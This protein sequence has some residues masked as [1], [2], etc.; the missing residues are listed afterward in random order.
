MDSG[1]AHALNDLNRFVDQRSGFFEEEAMAVKDHWVAGHGWLEKAQE[2]GPDGRPFVYTQYVDP[3]EM[4]PD[5]FG[6]RRD[7]RDHRYVLRSKWLDLDEA[8]ET[9]PEKEQALLQCIGNSSGYHGIHGMLDPSWEDINEMNYVD[10][11]RKRLRLFEVWYRR[12]A[13]RKA[14]IT[15]DGVVVTI[16]SIGLTNSARAI[17]RAGFE[18]VKTIIDEMWVGIFCGMTLIHH[19]RSPY[20]HGDYP[21]VQYVYSRNKSGMP[22]GWLSEDIMTMQDAHNKRHS[23]A[24]H[25]FNT[26]QAVVTEN[27]VKDMNELAEEMAKPD[28]VIVLEQGRKIDD[29]FQLLSNTEMGQG[30]LAM[31]QHVRQGFD[32]VG[33][34]SQVDQGQAPGDV[35]SDRGLA[36]LEA[37]NAGMESEVIAGITASRKRGLL[38][39]TALIQ[40]FFTDDMVFQVTD[41]PDTVREVRIGSVDLAAMRRYYIDLVMVEE[42]DFATSRQQQLDMLATTLPQMMQYGPGVAA[43]L[44]QMTDLRDKEQLIEMLQAAGQPAPPEPKISLSLQWADMSLADRLVWALKLGFPQEMVQAMQGQGIPSK[45]ELTVQNDQAKQQS[46]ERM[47]GERLDL[48][49]LALDLKREQEDKGLQVKALG[50]AAQEETKRQAV[51]QKETTNASQ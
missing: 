10:A 44:I 26:K 21:F 16:D 15:E 51:Q 18:P 19:D 37:N 6:R 20:E 46:K 40:Q 12:K 33:G 3:F 43:L 22:I 45:T 48:Q 1:Y 9:Y 11:R 47:E 28:G 29:V 5:P 13:V 31:Y 8:I 41:D 7:L 17:R 36:R 4:W 34:V 38:L 42:N 25:L 32:E 49:A 2:R 30:Q 24:L 14:A 27:A 39:Q 35:R 50:M 23:K